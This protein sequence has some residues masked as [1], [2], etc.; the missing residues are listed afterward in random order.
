MVPMVLAGVVEDRDVVGAEP[1]APQLLA[2]AR[3]VSG[4]G[5]FQAP[6]VL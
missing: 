3:G 4:Q 2:E 1:L 5:L 6:A